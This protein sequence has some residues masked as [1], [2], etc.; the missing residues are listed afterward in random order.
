MRTVISMVFG[1]CEPIHCN[2]PREAVCKSSPRAYVIMKFFVTIR[3]SGMPV[4][5]IIGWLVSR[6]R[7]CML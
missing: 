7:V 3:W 1:K 4:F 5:V 2:C 6:A